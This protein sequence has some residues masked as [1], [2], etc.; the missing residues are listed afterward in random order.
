M[1]SVVD[2]LR[3]PYLLVP[4]ILSIIPFYHKAQKFCYLCEFP[5]LLHFFL[6]SVPAH[7]FL[8]YEEQHNTN[9]LTRNIR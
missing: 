3:R 7:Q 9:P 6:L 2:A 5:I 1:D 8:C 4:Q